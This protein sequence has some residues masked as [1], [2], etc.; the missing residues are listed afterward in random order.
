NLAHA[1]VRFYQPVVPLVAIPAADDPLDLAP[2]R[3]LLGVGR[4]HE[5]VGLA[6]EPRE[7]RALDGPA[8]VLP[9][10]RLGAADGQELAVARLVDRV[11]G[12]GTAQ[13]PLATARRRAVAEE[14]AHVGG[15]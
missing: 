6:R 4:P 9:Q 13:E 7:V 5:L 1:D 11:I 12:V 10:P 3:F 14:E 2:G 8:E 15:G